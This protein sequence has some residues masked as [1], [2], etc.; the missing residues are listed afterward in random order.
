MVA[1]QEPLKIYSIGHSNH[2]PDTLIRLL[3]SNEVTAVVDTRSQPYS[4]YSPQFNH[5]SL[6]SL[7]EQAGIEY[8]FAGDTLGG[9]PRAAEFYDRE[10][11]VLYYRV[12]ESDFFALGL[13]RLRFLAESYDRVALLCSE[14][15]PTDCHRRLLIA[16]VLASEGIDVLHIR[17]DGRVQTESDL[18]GRQKVSSFAQ[19]GLFDGA[20]VSAWK[21][22]RSVL[23]ARP[24]SSSSSH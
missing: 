9:R 14:E 5:H 8:V 12:A 11:H 6:A 10:G 21:S 15:D 2:Q 13:S 1:V 19:P 7:L 17:G 4:Q 18:A 23:P 20:E 3:R 24:R 22:T 16:R